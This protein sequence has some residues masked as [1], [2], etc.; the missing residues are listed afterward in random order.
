MMCERCGCP[1]ADTGPLCGDCVDVLPP[2]MRAEWGAPKPRPRE[3]RARSVSK[4]CGVSGCSRDAA[5]DR[6]M[7]H[8]HRGRWRRGV[9]GAELEK[10]IANR[11]YRKGRGNPGP[12]SL[13]EAA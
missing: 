13:G 9:R 8:G 1:T 7:C 10:P 5:D 3:R 11:N 4:M 6:S 12:S 2:S